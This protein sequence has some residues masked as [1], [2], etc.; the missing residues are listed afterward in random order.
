MKLKL[1]VASAIFACSSVVLAQS[2]VTLSYADRTVDS[3]GQGVDVTR[4]SA[5]TKLFSNIDGDVGINQ[6]VNRVTNSVTS[7]KEVGLS[8]GIG[9][10]DFAKA[11][12]RVAGGI[13]SASGKDGV[14][15]YSIEPG[16]NFKLPVDGF[17]ARVAYRYRNA[18]DVSDN[19]RSDTMRYA[20]NY[21][22][23]KVDKISVGYDVLTGDGAHKQTV[24]SYTRSF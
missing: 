22:L 8:T 16:I 15:Y 4:L 13:K 3:N 6:A 1:L 19:D 24:F 14:E 5:K 20:L 12:I 9:I 17:S 11:T 10:T 7:R 21:D 2:S 23:S 18:F